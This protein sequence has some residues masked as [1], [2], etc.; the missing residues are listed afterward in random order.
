[1]DVSQPYVSMWEASS[2]VSPYDSMMTSSKCIVQ[3]MVFDRMNE[4]NTIV[5][6]SYLRILSASSI[7]GLFYASNPR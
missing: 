4:E 6:R 7:L 5:F 2:F 1:M 3:L